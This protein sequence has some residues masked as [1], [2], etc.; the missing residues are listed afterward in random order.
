VLNVWLRSIAG[1]PDPD[2]QFMVLPRPARRLQQ[3][4]LGRIFS[5]SNY[6]LHFEYRPIQFGNG[7]NRVNVNNKNDTCLIKAP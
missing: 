3:S 6:R 2:L 7:S 5:G 1:F 4:R